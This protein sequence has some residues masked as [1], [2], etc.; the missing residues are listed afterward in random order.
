MVFNPSDCTHARTRLVFW[1]SHNSQL[2]GME[3]ER[4]FVIIGKSV[5][6]K[7]VQE[8]S[9]ETLCPD[10]APIRNTGALQGLW[11]EYYA[12]RKE[13]F[14]AKR[15]DMKLSFYER[16]NG[17]KMH[18]PSYLKTDKW[19]NIRDKIMARAGGV[20]EGCLERPATQVHHATYNNIYDELAFQLVALCRP[21]H[22]KV[23][24]IASDDEW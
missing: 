9:E 16:S 11:E 15:Q 20:C 22:E 2:Y 18:Y 4:C 24:H 7:R 12:N 1:D 5:G 8:L 23:H 14:E 3:C 17:V 10:T 21:C 13:E 19:A 6:I